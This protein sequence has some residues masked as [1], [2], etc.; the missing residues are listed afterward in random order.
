VFIAAA[1]A[2]LAAAVAVCVAAVAL[3]PVVAVCGG[4]V[5]VSMV[6][7]LTRVHRPHPGPAP[8]H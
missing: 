3:I 7:R 1:A 6:A 4:L 5:L 8:V 2:T